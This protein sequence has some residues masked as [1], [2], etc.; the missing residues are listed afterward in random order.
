MSPSLK[1]F[2]PVGTLGFDIVRKPES[3]RSQEL[4]DKA[5]STG[6][7]IKGI[8]SVSDRLR[9]VGREFGAS[10]QREQLYW[11]EILSLKEDG[12]NVMRVPNQPSMHRIHFASLEG[13]LYLLE[14]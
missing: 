5:I 4:D 11:E 10:V 9:N 7:T 3:D 1:Q 8:S 14:H 13:T 6:W 12:W 2:I